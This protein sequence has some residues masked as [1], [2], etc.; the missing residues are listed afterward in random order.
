VSELPRFLVQIVVVL[1]PDMPPEE[2]A[3]LLEREASR[4]GELMEAGVIRDIWRI[5]GRLENVGVWEAQ[6]A[7]VLHQAISSLPVWP[8]TQVTVTPLANH[9]LTRDPEPTA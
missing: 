5:P 8:W 2:K 1:P 4:A 3:A 6:N 7:T 9:Y